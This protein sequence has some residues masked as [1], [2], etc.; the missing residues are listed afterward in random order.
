MRPALRNAEA[1]NDFALDAGVGVEKR[2]IFVH[3]L[4]R[5]KTVRRIDEERDRQCQWTKRSQST[6]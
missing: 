3:W 1:A 2:D 5:C 6:D 4:L